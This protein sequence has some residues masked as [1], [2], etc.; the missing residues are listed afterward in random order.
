MPGLPLRWTSAGAGNP[1]ATT[2]RH[3]RPPLP[4]PGPA[5]G[6]SSAKPAIADTTGLPLGTVKSL[7]LRAQGK[8]R[9]ALSDLP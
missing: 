1:A 4:T 6:C 8:L 3:P 5:T 7:I 2:R 9:Q